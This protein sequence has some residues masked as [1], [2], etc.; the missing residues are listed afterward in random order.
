MGALEKWTIKEGSL[1]YLESPDY[2]TCDIMQEG[3]TPYII[4]VYAKSEKECLSRAK[5]ICAVNE[6]EAAL[7]GISRIKDLLCYP[8]DVP[9]EHIDEAKAV[10]SALSDVESLLKDL[11]S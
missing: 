1:N 10:S 3:E 8:L 9:F 6:M 5:R 7:K 4:T 11:E 2:W